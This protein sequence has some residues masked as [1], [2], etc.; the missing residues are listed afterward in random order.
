M[1]LNTKLVSNGYY[2]QESRKLHSY[3]LSHYPIGGQGFS[4]WFINIVSC[5]VTIC[6]TDTMYKVKVHH[7][8]KWQQRG[9]VSVIVLR[10]IPLFAALHIIH[11]WGWGQ[12]S[13]STFWLHL[14]SYSTC[15]LVW[16]LPNFWKLKFTSLTKWTQLSRQRIT[17]AI[18]KKLFW[19]WL[20]SW[21]F[22][23]KLEI[24]VADI[25]KSES[26]QFWQKRWPHDKWGGELD[27]RNPEWESCQFVGKTWTLKVNITR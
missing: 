13:S 22:L 27:L 16:K 12:S 21:I 14:S 7:I 10:S 8:R 23:S 5:F 9:Q 19:Q 4:S 15:Q 20:K 24:K 6:I 11:V 1:W 2:S 17:L 25:D 3:S 26:C 18:P